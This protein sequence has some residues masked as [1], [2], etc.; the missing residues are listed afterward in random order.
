M[1]AL[2]VLTEINYRVLGCSN[3]LFGHNSEPDFVS[4]TY[5]AEASF[6]FINLDQSYFVN[7]DKIYRALLLG[8]PDER[9]GLNCLKRKRWLIIE[10]DLHQKQEIKRESN[11]TFFTCFSV[12]NFILT[13]LSLLSSWCWKFKHIFSFTHVRN[14][15]EFSQINAIFILFFSETLDSHVSGDCLALALWKGKVCLLTW[16]WEVASNSS[17][18]F[19]TDV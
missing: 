1:V 14:F 8:E 9:V 13:F 18:L 15:V 10:I 5:M 6:D 16:E 11:G 19:L 17:F 4:R 3:I 2:E 7:L 12:S